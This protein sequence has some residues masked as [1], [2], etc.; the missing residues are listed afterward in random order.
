MA[1]DSGIDPRYAAQFQRGFDPAVHVADRPREPRGPLR[2]QGGPPPVV[3]RVAPPPPMVERPVEPAP[4]IERPVATHP[5]ADELPAD[6]PEFPTPRPRLEWAVLVVGLGM[7]GLAVL[8][9]LR[10]VDL[11]IQYSGSGSAFA[12]QLNALAVNV[13]PGPLLIAGVVAVCLWIVLRAV[14]LPRSER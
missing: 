8:L 14:R 6:E 2:I 7:L 11:S 1:T 13:L 9:F 4:R 3:Q 12:D 5:P 10:A